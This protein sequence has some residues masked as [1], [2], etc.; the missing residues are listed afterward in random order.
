TPEKGYEWFGGA[1]G[2]EALTA[3][4]LLEFIDMKAVYGNVDDA[5]ILRTG[6]WLKKRRDGKGGYSR[7]DRALDSFGGA[8]PDVTNAY[9]TW[10]LSEARLPDIDTEVSAQERA[11]TTVTDPYLLA[12][13]TNTLFNAGRTSAAEAAARKLASLQDASGA[14]LKADHS[15]T[16]SGGENLTTETTSLAVLALLKSSSKHPEETRKAVEW[17]MKNR[18]AYGEWGATQATVLAL[19]AFVAYIEATKKTQGPGTVIVQVN[20]KVHKTVNYEAGHK[21]PIVVDGLSAL[22]TSGAN[23]V[24]VLVD[25][26]DAL[27]YTLVV[28][29][30][31]LQPASS[32][33][34]VVALSVKADKASVKM[35][36][37]VRVTA[38]VTNTT[39][40]G[41]PMTIARIGIPGGLAYQDWQ[42]KKL[43]EDKKIAFYETRAREVILYF[44]DLAPK[45]VHEI[46]IDLIAQVPGNYTAP[47]STAYLYYTDEHKVWAPALQTD[48]T[49]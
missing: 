12:L 46:P 15:I 33:S 14:W 10:A 18:G 1:P 29:H 44:R 43:R 39:D 25:G 38:T 23:E 21:D 7:N 31:S 45:A 8:S 47:A 27:P 20:G 17:M 28:T 30:R 22:L 48:V 40:A 9:I 34:A 32:P 37:P 11:S 5:M 26:Q 42:L 3:Y 2:H 13:A 16:R 36:E 35:G 41:Q 6:E 49:H 19:K 24:K 4:G